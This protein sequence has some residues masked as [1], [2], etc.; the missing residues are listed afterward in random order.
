MRVVIDT[1]VLVSAALRNRD[2]E[3]VILFVVGHP[4]MEWVVSPAIM[5]EY[6]NVL[7]RPKLK[8]LETNRQ[9]WLDLLRTSVT[10]IEPPP[11][12]E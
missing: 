5:T 12:V 3:A 11:S 9:E 6:L 2:P 10:W 4:G 8:L 1:N 7:A